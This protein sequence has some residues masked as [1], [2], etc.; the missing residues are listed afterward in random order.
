MT[1]EGKGLLAGVRLGFVGAGNM[2]MAIMGGLLTGGRVPRG[3]L[4]FY[5]PDAA[6]QAEVASYG[7]QAAED[8]REVLQASCVVLAVKPQAMTTVLAEIAPLATSRHLIISIAAGV[9]LKI[10]EAALPKSRLIRAMPN[11]PALVGAGMTALA[12]GSLATREDEMLALELFDAVGLAVAV[13]EKLLDAV[14]GLSGSGP[15]FAAVFIQALADGG[16]K[17]GLPRTLALQ[18]AIQTVLGTACLCLEQ[19]LHPEVLKD[20]V[21]SPGGTTIAGL[22]ALEK[23]GFRGLTMSAVAA[24][25]ARSKELGEGK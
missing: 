7:V 3:N 21:A 24:A 22:H 23:G 5:D 20:Q 12:P 17:M 9:P 16:V 18:M 10:L 6:R 15:A 13:D 25:T 2:G 19:E 4:I 8:N 1:E 14:T 11:T